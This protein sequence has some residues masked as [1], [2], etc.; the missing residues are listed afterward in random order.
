MEVFSPDNFNKIKYLELVSIFGKMKK[1]TLATGLTIKCTDV[2][3]LHGKME[4][5]MKVNSK[6]I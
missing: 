6:T 5:V 4:K 3:N 2:G 1:A